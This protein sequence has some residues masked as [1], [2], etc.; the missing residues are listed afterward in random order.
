MTPDQNNDKIKRLQLSHDRYEKLRKL[1]PRQFD[2]LW[3]ESV[4]GKFTFNE[5]VD[6]L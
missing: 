3:Q 1:N 5:L 2:E 4:R 6:K